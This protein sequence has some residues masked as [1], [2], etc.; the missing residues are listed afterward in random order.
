[1]PHRVE[2]AGK[3]WAVRSYLTGKRLKKTYATKAAA[4]KRAATSY[5]RSNRKRSTKRRY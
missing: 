5:R 1:M 2:K 4:Q 3:R